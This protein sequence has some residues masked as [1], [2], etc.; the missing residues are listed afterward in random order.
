MA[1][2]LQS[3]VRNILRGKASDRGERAAP[4]QPNDED[5]LP[6]HKPQRVLIGITANRRIKS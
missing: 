6:L 2:R 1:Q 3:M 5:D 4:A